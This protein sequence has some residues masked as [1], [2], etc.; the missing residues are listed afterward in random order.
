MKG[1]C[2][3]DTGLITRARTAEIRAA[4]EWEEKDV[5]CVESQRNGAGLNE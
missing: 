3:R 5:D 1:G 4:C 2:G